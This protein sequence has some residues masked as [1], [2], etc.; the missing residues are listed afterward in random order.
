M[1]GSASYAILFLGTLLEALVVV[2]AVRRKVLK[3]YFVLNLCMLLCVGVSLGRF[4]ILTHDGGLK[5]I[6]Y[7]YFYFYSDALLTIVLYFG[8]ISLYIS[9]FEEMKVERYLRMGAIVL[10]AGT[11]WFTYAVV[12]QS[13]HKILTYFAFEL[14]Q[15]L[16]FVGLVLTFV[17]WGAI[18]KL[19]ET[20]T[21]LIH[22]LLSLGVYF[23]SYS[24][25]FSLGN[26]FP[27]SLQ[28]VA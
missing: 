23:S 4:H 28:Y 6:T 12:S 5:S 22:L 8:L 20:L 14:S 27:N 26:I 17:L 10:L 24:A 11:S 7:R 2:C 18:L 15:N 3:K 21:Q 19:R 13:S 1:P 16:Y 25:T 9:V